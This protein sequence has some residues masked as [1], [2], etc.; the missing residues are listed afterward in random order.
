MLTNGNSKHD[1]RENVHCGKIVDN[2]LVLFRK[3]FL[4][5]RVILGSSLLLFL[6]FYII[7][8]AAITLIY[9]FLLHSMALST[10]FPQWKFSRISCFELP[11]VNIF[12]L[13][14]RNYPS[15]S[16]EPSITRAGRKHFRN[17]TKEG[18]LWSFEG[19]SLI[20]K[21]IDISLC[22]TNIVVY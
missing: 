19:V 6:L 8:F 15:R 10:I 22:I 2:A 3:C 5:A 11:L 17:K 7:T 21:E 1:I 14:A 12:I 18:K 20:I 16:D 9:L 4:P 13:F